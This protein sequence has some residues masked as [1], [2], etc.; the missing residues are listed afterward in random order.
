MRILLI[1]L[2]FGAGLF[3]TSCGSHPEPAANELFTLV[4]AEKSNLHFTNQLTEGL[5]T[6]VLLYEYFYNGGG[7]AIADLNGDGWEDIYFTGNMTENKLFLNKGQ[8]RFE[9]VTAAAGV[10]GRPGPWKTGVCIAD[11]NGDGRPDIFLCYSGKVHGAKRVKQLFINEGNDAQGI[12]KFSEQAAQYGLADSAYTTQAYFFDYDRDGDLDLLLLNHNPKNLPMLNEV[13][14]AEIMKRPNP[15]TG[16]RLLRNDGGH[17]H[18]VTEAAGISSSDLSYGLGAGIADIDGDG[19][20]DVYISNDYAVPD[21]LYIN[22]HD[23]RFVNR[24]AQSIG[25]TSQFS[26]GNAVADVNNDGRM[27]IFTLDMLPEDNRRQKLLFAPDNY[28]KFDLNLRSGFYYQYMRNMLQLN[29]GDGSFSEIG[30]LAGVANTDWSWAP[31]WAD[32][33]NDGWKDLFVTNGYVRDYTN[34]D[35][36]KFMEKYTQEKGRLKRE[37][38]LDI[39]DH[40]PSSNVTSYAFR[41]DSG[42]QFTSMGSRWGITTPSNSNGAAW[43]DLDHDGDLDLVVNNLNKEAFLYEN[44]ASQLTRPHWL[45]VNTKGTGMNTVGIGAK[46]WVYAH[47]RMQYLEQEPAQGYQSCVS[48]VLHFGLGTDSIVDSLRII[49]PRGDEQLLT[50]LAANQTLQ[51]DEKNAAIKPAALP[52]S[53]PAVFHEVPSPVTMKYN[54]PVLNDFKRQP[55]LVSAL[56]YVGPCMAKADVNGDGI[57]DLFVGDGSGAAGRIFL[58]HRDGAFTPVTI[59]AFA[60]DSGRE[61]ADALFF[62]ANGDGHPDLYVVAGGYNHFIPGDSL[63]QDRLYLGDG[64]GHFTRAIGALPPMGVAKSCV[65]AADVNGDGITDLFI[66]GRVI[67]GQYPETPSSYLLIGDGKGHFTDRTAELA[68]QLRQI[69]MV[70][71]AAWADLDGD[72]KKELLVV[73]E[74]MPIRVFRIEKGKLTEHTSDYFD[75]PWSGW[76]N[77][78]LVE[79][80][81]GDGRPEIVIG[82]LG[83]NAQCKADEQHPAELYYR[84]FDGNGTTD[85]ILCTYIGDTSYPFMTRDELIAQV[86]GMSQKFPD[87]KSFANARLSDI[88]PSAAIAGAGHLQAQC[89][90]TVLLKRSG[91]GKYREQP[92][93]P[94]VQYSP[95]YTIT[96]LDYDGDGQKDLLFCGNSQHARL[97]FGKYDANYGV[98]LKGDGKGGFR[99]VPQPVSGFHLHGDVRSVIASQGW[100]LFGIN[101][102]GIRAYSGK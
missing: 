31:L 29:N 32:F 90:R 66:G 46:L 8:L 26:M 68:P 39:V 54:R 88:F 78:L 6:N 1:G 98:L 83:T 65:R 60:A 102:E 64:K 11:V 48:P 34:M 50:H 30:Q 87:Y 16:L 55:Q 5:N 69:G 53:T 33:D 62:D 75:R 63:L 101:G 12:P 92:L 86:S 97:R 67:P 94:E 76:W 13:S 27:D 24:L 41:N 52:A 36:I 9:D 61:A 40:M 15:M 51:L 3:F 95:I 42:R 7:V 49:W 25:H 72:G 43:A 10:A 81:D 100:L 14:T 45:Q 84:D 22:Q 18:D 89:L 21:Y 85:P 80:L 59:P 2:L 38:V 91:A 74:W 47:G 73:G 96:A 23:G 56:S 44:H 57:D 37:D 17:F 82:N 71:D 20:P 79:D 58:G 35:F 77:R 28:E 19:W 4:P 93:P 70:T 99:Y